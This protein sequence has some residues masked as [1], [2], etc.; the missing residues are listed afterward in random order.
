MMYIVINLLTEERGVFETAHGTALY[1]W[2]RDFEQYRIF[3][4]GVIFPWLDGDLAAF[5][6]ALE[7][8]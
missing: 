3:K 2:G 6:Q 1:M 8:V 7:A 4:R 5:E